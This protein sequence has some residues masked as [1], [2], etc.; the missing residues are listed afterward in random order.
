LANISNAT[1]RELSGLT[2]L[3]YPVILM[4]VSTYRVG[5]KSEPLTFVHIFAKY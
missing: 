5:H 2:F 3:A 4:I 1:N